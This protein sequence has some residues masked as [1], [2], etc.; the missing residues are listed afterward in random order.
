MNINKPWQ[1]WS[2]VYFSTHIERKAA[3]V[4]KKELWWI[5][6]YSYLLANCAIHE[7]MRAT[8]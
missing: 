1:P 8:A 6:E 3:T 7:I 2:K 5:D 4:G